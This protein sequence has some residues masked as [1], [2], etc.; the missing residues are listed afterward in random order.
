MSAYTDLLHTLADLITKHD[1]DENAVSTLTPWLLT[2]HFYGD[3]AKAQA[4]KW[5]RAIGGTWEKSDGGTTVDLTLRE[6]PLP[7]SPKVDMFISKDAC[8]RKVVGTETVVIPAV[9][10]RPERVEEREIVEWDCGP[11]LEGVTS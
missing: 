9:E 4:A 7:G 6:S 3:D 5:R 10:A 1:L 11:V 8:V 2:I